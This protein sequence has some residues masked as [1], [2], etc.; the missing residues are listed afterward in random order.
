MGSITPN[1]I[2]RNISSHNADPFHSTKQSAEGSEEHDKG[3]PMP[4]N[5]SPAQQSAKA[6]DEGLPLAFNQSSEAMRTM[7]QIGTYV[8][9]QMD[10]QYRT[11]T[12]FVLIIGEYARLM[13]W[14]RS[15]ILFTD[16]TYYNKHSELVE[17]FERYD[18]ALP[19]VRGSDKFVEPA[20]PEEISAALVMRPDTMTPLLAVSIL[21][22][23]IATSLGPR[24]LD[25]LS[26]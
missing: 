19:E 11:H 17:L 22:T 13:C 9:I 24:W 18:T 15:G 1:L 16:P 8:T 2:I 26:P 5:Q 21:G 10:L 3:L 7:G 14:D 12:F 4:L 25:L 6:S 20:L 23:P